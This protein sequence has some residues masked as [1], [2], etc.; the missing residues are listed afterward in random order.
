MGPD[1]PVYKLQG[2]ARL[3]W[4]GRSPKKIGVAVSGYIAAMRAVRRKVHTVWAACVR[5]SRSPKG[6]FAIWKQQG[7]VVSLFA[8]FDTWVLQHSQRVWLW[9]IEYFRQ[10]LRE[11]KN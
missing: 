1:R 8:V 6:W 7:Q 2:H 10:R 11:F 3:S 9:R 4:A 5:E